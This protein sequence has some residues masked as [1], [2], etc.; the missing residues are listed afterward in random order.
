MSEIPPPLEQLTLR[1][2]AMPRDTNPSGDIFGGWLV[3]IMDMAGGTIAIHEAKGRVVLAAIDKMSFLR[4]VF[5]GDEVS[6]YCHI[7]KR[8]NTSMQV[9]IESWVRRPKDGII[10]KVTEGLFTFVAIDDERK[11]R[12]LQ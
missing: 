6:C 5:V 1:V 4:P 7:V 8:G 2:I 9:S 11:P 12:S 10:H 3:S